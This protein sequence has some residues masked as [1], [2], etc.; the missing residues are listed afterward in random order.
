[1]V[2]TARLLWLV[3]AAL[4]ASAGAAGASPSAVG[5]AAVPG[6]VVQGTPAHVVVRARNATTCSLR[7][8][9]HGGST[10]AGLGLARVVAGRAQWTWSVPTDVQAGAAKATVRCGRTSIGRQFVVV[11]RV[12]A[13]SILVV[14]SG[15]TTR[16]DSSGSTRLS[17]GVM[18]HNTAGDR[19]A[20][21]VTVQT[22]FVMADDHLLG[23]DTQRLPGVGASGDFA[24]GNTVYFPGAA[25]IARLEFVVRV[26]G[27]Q[28][29]RLVLPTLANIHL[30][31]ESF[32]PQ[33]LGTIEGELQNTSPVLTLQMAALSGVVLDASGAIIGG[34]SSGFLTGALPAGARS[35]LKMSNLDAIPSDRAASAVVSVWPT[36]T[37][38]G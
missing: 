13:P 7:V 35:F 28:P 26:D 34:T 19:D 18:L 37:Q 23:T 8:T 4:A 21:N 14:Q 30:E 12:P 1:M 10:Q 31:P 15:F 11:G 20:V 25:P 16:V 24:F 22:N 33:W 2:R 5:F 3:A 36:W 27:F 29:H 9:Y 38:P 32:Q 17:Y 6:H